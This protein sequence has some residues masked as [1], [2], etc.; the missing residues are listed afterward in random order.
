VERKLVEVE[1]LMNDLF[2][3]YPSCLPGLYDAYQF[4]SDV[5]LDI[6]SNEVTNL[7]IYLGDSFE[8]TLN[9]LVTGLQSQA[10]ASQQRIRIIS[11]GL[12]FIL[13]LFVLFL[14]LNMI[15]V[16][17]A[18]LS[19]LQSSMEVLATGD[20]SRHLLVKGK[21][22]LSSLAEA[23][24]TFI[25]D[26]STVIDEVKA[27]SVDSA[28]LKDQVNSAT[29][30]SA[31]AVAQMSANISSISRQ[32]ENLVDSLTTSNEATGKIAQ[33]INALVDRIEE[34]SSAALK[35]WQQASKALRG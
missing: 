23:M 3:T 21:D 34:Q 10:A 5:N 13:L 27:I 24:N 17:R 7:T 11:L 14:S 32:I 19:G 20:F 35:R 16:L 30:E 28:D 6:A 8:S 31:A 22:E 25:D 12:V 4:Y 1:D 29:N 18:Q 9:E 33:G 26:F 2:T 15:R